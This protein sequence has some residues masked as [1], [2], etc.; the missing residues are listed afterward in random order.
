M[1]N[2][3]TI[4]Q[5]VADT[6]ADIRS[7]KS[8]CKWM[9]C[10]VNEGT[11]CTVEHKGDTDWEDFLTKVP[12]NEPRLIIFDLKFNSDDGRIIQKLVYIKYT[13]DECTN[14]TLKFQYANA[15]NAFKQVCQPF[16]RELQK[17]DK[18]DMNRER[19]ISDL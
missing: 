15:S 9:I 8:P 12:Q 19:I 2:S 16:N 14:T 1:N 6:F 18:N 10:M 4:G 13:P 7:N 11:Q 17:N 5:D 3:I